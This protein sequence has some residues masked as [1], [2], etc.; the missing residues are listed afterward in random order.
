M[1]R[2]SS[3]NTRTTTNLYV[4]I[5]G[6]LLRNEDGTIHFCFG[7]Y[8]NFNEE[9]GHRLP[10]SAPPT[11]PMA[12]AFDINTAAASSIHSMGHRLPS[13]APPTPPMTSVMAE[14]TKFTRRQYVSSLY[15]HEEMGQVGSVNTRTTTNLYVPISRDSLKK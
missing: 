10:S 3:V 6:I 13:S 8:Y 12:Q 7:G 11:P 14:M 4:P 1:E 9:M 5:P 15:V 2:V